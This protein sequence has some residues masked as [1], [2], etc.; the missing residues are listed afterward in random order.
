MKARLMVASRYLSWLLVTTGFGWLTLNVSMLPAQPGK[1][2][3]AKAQEEKI[4][5]TKD[6]FQE[7]QID[8]GDVDTGPFEK[9]LPFGKFLSRLE[10]QIPADKPLRLKI[11]EAAFGK[12]LNK[13][14]EMEILIPIWSPRMHISTLLR[15][16]LHRLPVPADFRYGPGEI[17]V[18]TPDRARFMAEYDV[19]DLLKPEK[20]V[21]WHPSNLPDDPVVGLLHHL[22]SGSPHYWRPTTPG[23]G[24]IHL[25]NETRLVVDANADQHE[26]VQNALDVLRRVAD[27]AV[28]MKAKVVEVNQGFFEKHVQPLLKGKTADDDP[29]GGIA[30]SP[31]MLKLLN[32]QKVISKGQDLRIPPGAKVQFLSW[33]D[34]FRY[35]PHPA[36]IS[37]GLSLVEPEE[38][39]L[40]AGGGFR[41][42]LTARHG[43]T[44]S[45]K[46]KISA[47]R[48]F[49]HLVITQNATEIKALTVFQAQEPA[50]GHK[51]T[52]EIPK[53][54]NRSRSVTL[55]VGDSQPILVP[56]VY[57]PFPDKKDHHWLLVAEPM[58]YIEEEQE[59]IRK[60]ELPPKS[61]PKL[62][63]KETAKPLT[64]RPESS[65]PKSKKTEQILNAILNDVLTSPG[66]KSS[67]TFYGTP[68]DRTFTLEDTSKV[69]W[70]AWF[71]PSI[72]GFK[73]IHLDP[74]NLPPF[75]NKVLGIAI[76]RWDMSPKHGEAS[77]VEIKIHIFNAGG[78]ENGAVVGACFISY[79]AFQKGGKWGV[80]CTGWLD[81]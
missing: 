39:E 29:Q 6:R 36:G 14:L 7:I 54:E 69:A 76:D 78:E 71:R 24:T 55:V 72:P 9:P 32:G 70:P 43:F 19:A 77:D 46:A 11:D 27:L 23:H 12:D 15:A 49:L 10:K 13:V 40:A 45:V 17:I 33:F 38:A 8:T 80:Q 68:K 35:R 52:F 1:T 56:S 67:R 63:E 3:P 31:E 37:K 41:D 20:S 66:L 58:I 16:A 50:I 4:A 21:T 59:L 18:T 75:Q 48:R 26:L 28:V 61:P 73:R 34:F 25:V 30:I 60:G 22:T 42:T 79:V 51:V 65:L 2:P 81:P 53:L 57:R 74:E 44:V 47:D 5:E 64:K 62:P